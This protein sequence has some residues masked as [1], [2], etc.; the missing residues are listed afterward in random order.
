MNP[1][2]GRSHLGVLLAVKPLGH[3]A[4]GAAT[5]S[6]GLVLLLGK[7]GLSRLRLESMIILQLVR[8]RGS[9]DVVLR[10]TLVLAQGGQAASD[11]R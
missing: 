7:H 8:G 1:V 4:I 6:H 3:T 10:R 5:T 9:D 11:E 2:Q